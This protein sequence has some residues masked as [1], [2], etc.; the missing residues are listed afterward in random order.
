MAHYETSKKKKGLTQDLTWVDVRVVTNSLAMLRHAPRPCSSNPNRN[1]RC[2]ASV[3]ET[4]FR[5]LA[6]VSAAFLRLMFLKAFFEFDCITGPSSLMSKYIWECSCTWSLHCYCLDP[7]C[8]LHWGVTRRQ[9][10][11]PTTTSR[12]LALQ[13]LYTPLAP[14]Q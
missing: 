2:S 14:T 12:G 6:L 7:A 5:W 4:P 3:H 1:R 11:V 13:L 10:L 8:W 9:A